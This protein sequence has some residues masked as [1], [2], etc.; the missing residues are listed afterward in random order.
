MTRSSNLSVARGVAFR[1]VTALLKN[2]ALFIPPMLFPLMSFA[3]FAGGLS[4]L[5]QIPDFDYAAGY[6]SFQFVFVLLQSACFGGVFM[7]LAIARD[8]ARA[9][10]G[11]LRLES[12]PGRGTTASLELPAA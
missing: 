4:R 1:T 6:T 12:S 11:D 9:M 2:P 7:G 3:A 8:F 5:S 10:G